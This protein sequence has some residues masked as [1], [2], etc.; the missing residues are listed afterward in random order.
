MQNSRLRTTL[1]G[2]SAVCTLAL[3]LGLAALPSAAN[4]QQSQPTPQI[5]NELP[6]PIA[7]A[8]GQTSRARPNLGRG[9]FVFVTRLPT[10]FSR[11]RPDYDAFG[12]K[13]DPFVIT[14]QMLVS[15]EYD[16]N[17]FATNTNEDDDFIF[18][19]RP[20]VRVATDFSEHLIGV[21]GFARIVRFA[22]EDSENIEEGGANM[23]GRYD[24]SSE[25]SFFG[26]VGW[27]RDVE[28]RIDP[29]FVGG[30]RGKSDTLTGRVGYTQRFAS[31]T[32]DGAAEYRNIDFLNSADTDRDRDEYGARVRVRYAWVPR[33]S[34]TVQVD[35]LHRSY[36]DSVD[37][38][39][40][41]RDVDRYGIGVGALVD[42]TD[43]I[44]GDFLIGAQRSEPDDPTLDGFWAFSASGNVIW[45]ITELTSIIAGLQRSEEATAVTGAAGRVS[46]TADLRV[47]HELLRNLL[48]SADLGYRNDDFRSTTR[49]EDTI[50]AGIGAEYL[51]NRYVS[52]VADYTFSDRDSSIAGGD[53]SKNVFFVGARLQL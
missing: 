34:P 8:F 12:I 11:S 35:Y 29:E 5:A 33:I 26:N 49:D 39:G 13:A 37:S 21:E 41:N 36:K 52:I 32:V 17:V 30:Q 7:P 4:A 25:A 19:W 2:G 24:L 22:S 53:Y 50:S 42:I 51:L 18:T 1:F 45:N 16:D 48:V 43:L 47:E 14:P 10:V 9:D 15:A 46:S 6:K 23:F 28:E 38:T 3:S 40:L 44:Q 27:V 20:A 31:F